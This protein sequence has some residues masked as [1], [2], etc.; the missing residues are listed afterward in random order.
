MSADLRI[1]EL[2][3]DAIDEAR[4]EHPIHPRARPRP[5]SEADAGD[6]EY[7]FRM[8]RAAMKAFSEHAVPY[9]LATASLP[10]GQPSHD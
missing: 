3:A 5:F 1:V 2:I 4:Y 10:A 9:I 7:A 6:R 8:A